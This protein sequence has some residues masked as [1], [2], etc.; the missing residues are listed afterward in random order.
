MCSGTVSSEVSYAVVLSQ[1]IAVLCV[2]GGGWGQG[3][4]WSQ[5]EKAPP[6][7]LT[8]IE[9]QPYRVAIQIE[10]EDAAPQTERLVRQIRQDL[11]PALERTIGSV[12]ELVSTEAAVAEE[13]VTLTSETTTPHKPVVR[14]RDTDIVFRLALRQLSGRTQLTIQTREPL[15]S[16]ESPV[17]TIVT[18]D[19]RELIS[20]LLPVLVRLFRPQAEWDRVDDHTVRLRVRGRAL[21]IPDPD[22]HLFRNDETFALWIVYRTREGLPQRVSAIPWTL[23][24]LSPAATADTSSVEASTEDAA[25][26]DAAEESAGL[27][28]VWSGLRSPVARRPRGRVE[29][30]A[31]ACRPL[32]PRTELE[33]VSG[34]NPPR[35]LVAHEVRIS[36]LAPRPGDEPL[37]WLRYSDRTGRVALDI[38]ESDLP[39]WVTIRSGHQT[40]ARIP[41]QPG[42]EPHLRI[43]L[44]DDQL[45]LRVEGQLQLLQGELVALVAKRR[46]LI[47]ACRASAKRAAWNEVDGYLQQL[48]ALPTSAQYR[49]QVSGIRVPAV[50]LARERKDVLSERR[51]NRLCDETLELLNRHLGEDSL[52]LIQEEMAE[53]RAAASEQ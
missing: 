17:E 52:R 3:V 12:W 35:L 11:P 16:Y 46:A 49:E 9:F 1:T 2:L 40:L 5:D 33:L 51:V 30:W 8:P 13:D 23:C 37:E 7:L 19:P 45:R 53:L 41:I 22:L 32:W 29:L 47:V 31:V 38:A 24:R 48:R 18:A 6:S 39:V 4:V 10:N 20:E 36:D 27:A 21:T 14:H 44:P 34:T 50:A 26:E 28:E 42:S 15:W 25:T 43:E